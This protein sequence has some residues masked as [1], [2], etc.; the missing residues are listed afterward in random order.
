MLKAGALGIATSRV[1]N[2]W[3]TKQALRAMRL[4]RL[5]VEEGEGVYHCMSRAA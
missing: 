1:E 4:A 5:K 3:K 2:H